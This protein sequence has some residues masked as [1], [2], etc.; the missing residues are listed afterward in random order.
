[1]DECRSELNDGSIQS[2]TLDDLAY[3]DPDL[4]PPENR[5][6]FQRLKCLVVN[7]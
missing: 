6:K 5:I 4:I 1:M 2:S 7:K 3:D